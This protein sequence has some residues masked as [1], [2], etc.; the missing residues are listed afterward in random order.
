MDFS[1]ANSLWYLKE[2]LETLTGKRS[3]GAGA[4][5][6][7]NAVAAVSEADKER[8]IR[9]IKDAVKVIENGVEANAKLAAASPAGGR[10]LRADIIRDMLAASKK[11]APYIDRDIDLVWTDS[12]YH[13]CATDGFRAFR[14]SPS[15]HV[16]VAKRR[17]PPE[18]PDMLDRI[19]VSADSL[20]D[21]LPLPAK[22]DLIALIA[23]H[24][25]WSNGERVPVFDFG[26]NAPSVNAEYLLDLMNFFPDVHCLM[27]DPSGG[28]LTPLFAKCADGDAVL[29][30]VRKDPP[31][32][33]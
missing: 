31:Q 10:K 20:I 9:Y 28:S 7:A 17:S 23:L 14:L 19:F 13:Q 33:S 4:A 5:Y 21:S 25:G 32:G 2:A 15:A 30:P 11:N 8:A 27:Y 22:H 6:L 18:K 24:K 12:H 29:L 1:Y 3:G 16:S 26:T